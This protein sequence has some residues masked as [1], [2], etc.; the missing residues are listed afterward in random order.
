MSKITSS[1]RNAYAPGKVRPG[2]RGPEKDPRCADPAE[3]APAGGTT[4]EDRPEMKTT[5]ETLYVIE[6]LT[7]PQVSALTGVSVDILDCWSAQSGWRDLRR[8][9]CEALSEIRRNTTLLRKRLLEKAIESLDPRMINAAARLE[10]SSGRKKAGEA[11]PE[12][13]FAGPGNR[14]IGSPGEAVAALQEAVERKLNILLNQP[15]TVSFGAVRELIKAIEL[16]ESMKSKHR[17]EPSD[18]APSGLSRDAAEEIRRKILGIADE[19]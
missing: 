7:L 1:Q 2:K 3:R 13:V 4:G 15:E 10:A 6:G 18:S 9:Y 19:G 14:A 5:A 12:Q 17:K 11:Q 16:I 8:E